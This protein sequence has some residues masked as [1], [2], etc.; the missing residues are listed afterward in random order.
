MTID[1]H[2][3]LTVG[4]IAIAHN[5]LGLIDSRHTLNGEYGIVGST[6]PIDGNKQGRHHVLKT[7]VDMVRTGLHDG[8][9]PHEVAGL[10]GRSAALV[11]MKHMAV[12]L[13][14]GTA[15]RHKYLL[16]APRLRCKHIG[17]GLRQIAIKQVGRI[18]R[19]VIAVDIILFGLGRGK[20]LESAAI[21]AQQ[22]EAVETAAIGVLAKLLVRRVRAYYLELDF[23][24]R[25]KGCTIDI[26]TGGRLAIELAHRGGYRKRARLLLRGLRLVGLAAH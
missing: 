16:L 6:Q 2:I 8:L 13:N 20:I 25:L 5:H 26:G 7:Q 10:I 3:Y 4:S 15:A 17:R 22:P 1:C 23:I 11:G 19:V 24:F 14:A 18:R 9:C 21:P 12:L